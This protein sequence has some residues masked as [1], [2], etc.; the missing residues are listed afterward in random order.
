M[1][2]SENPRE[3]ALYRKPRD[4][5]DRGTVEHFVK[6][7]RESGAAGND[8]KEDALKRHPHDEVGSRTEHFTDIE[9]RGED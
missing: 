9:R 8:P 6:T 3:K 1:S 5:N 2:E 7:D 4:H